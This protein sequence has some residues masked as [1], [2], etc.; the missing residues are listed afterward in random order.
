MDPQADPTNLIGHLLSLIDIMD[1]DDVADWLHHHVTRPTTNPQGIGI[2]WPIVLNFV[3][4]TS[5]FYELTRIL[6]L[7]TLIT[8]IQLLPLVCPTS[9]LDSFNMSRCSGYDTDDTQSQPRRT[10]RISTPLR[11]DPGMIQPSQDSR[12][13][14][15][16]PSSQ[17][18]SSSGL[19]R[20]RSTSRSDCD[21]VGGLNVPTQGQMSKTVNQAKPTSQQRSGIA[22]PK[23]S[24]K[25]TSVST[26]SSVIRA[27]GSKLKGKTRSKPK[28][29][30]TA[31]SV[32][33][34]SGYTNQNKEQGHPKLPTQEKFDG[35]APRL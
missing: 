25:P 17:P 29:D 2:G 11:L 1:D 31:S 9:R 13:G 23:G 5:N 20:A 32:T 8:P 35:F 18:P 10:S 21:V 30:S 6:N 14:L 24:T 15:F 27:S 26:A 12:R 19:K 34:A 3:T 33:N 4:P 28:P 22:K 16:N 7:T